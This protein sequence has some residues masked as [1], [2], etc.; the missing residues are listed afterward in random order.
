MKIGDLV[1][2]SLRPSQNTPGAPKLIWQQR[3]IGT[4]VNDRYQAG[5]VGYGVWCDVLWPDGKIA[6]CFKKDLEVIK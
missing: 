4:V 3:L 6:K 1:K 5:E 2:F